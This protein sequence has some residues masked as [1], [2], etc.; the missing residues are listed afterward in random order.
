VL[1]KRVVPDGPKRGVVVLAYQQATGRAE[2]S[3]RRY[4]RAKGWSLESYDTRAADAWR[5]LADAI[6]ELVPAGSDRG[7]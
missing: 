5:G 4:K 2:I 7:G 1:G 3:V 6:L